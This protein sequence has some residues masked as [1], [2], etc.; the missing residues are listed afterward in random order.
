VHPFAEFVS[1]ARS[2]IKRAI[3]QTMT[4]RGQDMSEATST[5]LKLVGGDFADDPC[6]YCGRTPSAARLEFRTPEKAGGRTVQYSFCTVH[7]SLARNYVNDVRAALERGEAPS[8]PKS[9]LE[10]MSQP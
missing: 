10:T 2:R 5:D 1:A 3:H 7:I 4:S 9:R 8:E 6:Y